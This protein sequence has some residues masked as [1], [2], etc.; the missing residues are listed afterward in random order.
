MLD[1][2]H[3]VRLFEVYETDNTLFMVMEFLYGGQ[4]QEYINKN[5]KFSIEEIRIIMKGLIDGASY[6]ASKSIF[7]KVILDIMH[8]DLKPKNIILK[9]QHDF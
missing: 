7:Y 8:R 1:H 3:I 4:L 6:L 5:Y 2:P 9:K